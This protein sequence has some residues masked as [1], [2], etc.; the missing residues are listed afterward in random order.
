MFID[1]YSRCSEWKLVFLFKSIW[2]DIVQC[3]R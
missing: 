1:V 3:E 2:A